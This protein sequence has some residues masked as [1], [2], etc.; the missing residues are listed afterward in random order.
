MTTNTVRK[1]AQRIYRRNA[2]TSEVL[3]AKEPKDRWRR[4]GGVT[5][6][7]LTYLERHSLG[8][9]D[10]D[11]VTVPFLSRITGIDPRTLHTALRRLSMP[12]VQGG[13]VMRDQMVRVI[14]WRYGSESGRNCRVA[15]YVLGRGKNK[16]KPPPIPENALQRK[17][18][19]EAKTRALTSVFVAGTPI[20]DRVAPPLAIRSKPRPT[21]DE[22]A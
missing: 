8:P 15:M 17:R 13:V 11:P 4:P 16:E 12:V 21:R 7:V 22:G 10:M 20:R 1:R 9:G 5:D 3:R 6:R 18:R 14:D 19:A 2:F